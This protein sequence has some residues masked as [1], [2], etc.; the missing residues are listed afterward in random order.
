MESNSAIYADSFIISS[1]SAIDNGRY[2]QCE[3]FIN[4]SQTIYTYGEVTIFF[5][6]E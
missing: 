5:S 6:G 3:V 4:A 2:F 1:L